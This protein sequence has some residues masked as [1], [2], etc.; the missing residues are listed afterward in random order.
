[1]SKRKGRE[2][3][4]DRPER[5]QL[6]WREYSLDQF[7]AP[8]HRVQIIWRYVQSL[9]LT[10]LEEKFKAVEGHQGRNPVDPRIL[11]ALWIYATTESVSSAREI[12][13]CCKS[14]LEYMWICGGVSVNYHLIADFRA[15]NQEFLEKILI[16]TVSSLLYSGAITLE[17]VAQDGMRTRAHAG[18][19]SFRRRASL[20]KCVAKAK[21]HVERLNEQE[22]APEGATAKQA[23]QQRAVDENLARAEEALRQVIKLDE[24]KEERRKGSGEK[25]RCS[26]TDPDA[27]IMKMGDGGFRPAYNVQLASDGKSR[28]IVS[29]QVTNSGNDHEQMV[30]M[31]EKIKKSYSKYPKKMLVDTGFSGKAA[32][33]Y[34]ESKGVEVYAPIHSEQQMKKRGKDPYVRHRKDTNEYFA[35][36]QRMSTPEAQAIYQQRSAIAEFPNAELRNRGLTQFRIRGLSRVLSSTLLYA[37]S[38]NFMR[39]VNLGLIQ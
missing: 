35:F 3:R 34:A 14:K 27:R 6:E 31:L 9:D 16:W 33:T 13:R 23:A 21:A 36:R 8:D 10:S 30:P 15:E 18:S 28:M 20:E 26:T 39:M 22:A 11:L 29:V 7:I 5:R 38:F 19:S 2:V 4:F 1:M 12:E 17:T 32:V 37:L 24:E 25:A